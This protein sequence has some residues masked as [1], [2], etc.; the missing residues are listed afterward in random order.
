[1]CGRPGRKKRGAWIK[2]T[3]KE[4]CVWILTKRQTRGRLPKSARPADTESSITFLDVPCLGRK[5]HRGKQKR[6][7]HNPERFCDIALNQVRCFQ[8]GLEGKET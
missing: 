4:G 3:I 1:M 5:V 2:T 7:W 8:L 6:H